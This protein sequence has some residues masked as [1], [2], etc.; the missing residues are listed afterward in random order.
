MSIVEKR[1]WVE[2]IKQGR[3]LE[4]ERILKVLNEATRHYSKTHY[5]GGYCQWCHI[6]ELIEEGDQE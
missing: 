5:E 4:R 3:K 2:G 6:N 1:Y